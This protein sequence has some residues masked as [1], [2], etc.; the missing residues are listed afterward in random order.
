VQ[1]DELR[2]LSSAVFGHRYRLE[3]LA[4]LVEAGEA[5]GVC[6]TQLADDCGV[7]SSVYYPS[8]KLLVSAGLVRRVG[9]AAGDA[10]VFYAPMQGPVWAGL[11]RMVED[12]GVETEFH[13]M[14]GN[15]PRTA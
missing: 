15:R 9:K 5:G 7:A 1:L 13:G 6:L 3:L 14:A 4:A 2:G 12:L 11:R 10:R 8:L